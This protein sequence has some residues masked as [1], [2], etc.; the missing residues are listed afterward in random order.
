MSD[1]TIVTGPTRVQV[2][3]EDEAFKYLLA[4]HH[5]VNA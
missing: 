4:L 1:R 3:G 5:N 2:F